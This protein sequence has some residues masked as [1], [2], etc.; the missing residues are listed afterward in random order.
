M[1]LNTVFFGYGQLEWQLTK[2]ERHSELVEESRVLTK[3]GS[4]AK[5]NV[6]PSWSRNLAC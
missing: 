3:G 2:K 1:R 6:I 4:L 5:K